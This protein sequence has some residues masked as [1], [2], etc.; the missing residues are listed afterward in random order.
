[1]LV[2]KVSVWLAAASIAILM[3]ISISLITGKGGTVDYMAVY[4]QYYSA[5]YADL[6][7]RSSETTEVDTPFERAL[8]MYNAANYKEAFQMLDNIAEESVPNEKYFLYKGISAMELGE[9]QAA[10]ELFD[11][12]MAHQVLKH[13][14]MWFKGLS[15]LAMEDEESARKV[16]EE[17][18][19]TDSNFN[20]EASSLLRSI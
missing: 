14:G 9:F 7:E 2:R 11:K 10:I 13:N 17:I 15:Y 1:V 3:V 8:R 4:E 20:E 18:I 5:P 16:F 6:G 12:L 19:S